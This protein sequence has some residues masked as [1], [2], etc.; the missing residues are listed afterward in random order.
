MPMK[1]VVQVVTAMNLLAREAP[2][3]GVLLTRCE[4]LEAGAHRVDLLRC[5]FGYF[6][7]FRVKKCNVVR[8]FFSLS[9]AKKESVGHS[10]AKVCPTWN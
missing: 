6:S 10:E 1:T 5:M 9:L 2:M 8:G 4:S 3:H 7:D